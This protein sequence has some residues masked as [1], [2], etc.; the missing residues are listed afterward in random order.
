M[1]DADKYSVTSIPQYRSGN[2]LQSFIAFHTQLTKWI[3]PFYVFDG[4][5]PIV[6]KEEKAKRYGMKK[7]TGKDYL[8]MRQRAIDNPKASFSKEELAGEE[9]EGTE[10]YGKSYSI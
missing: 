9:I 10:E 5:P 1:T 6:K 8:D 3:I 4:K 7:N 2:L